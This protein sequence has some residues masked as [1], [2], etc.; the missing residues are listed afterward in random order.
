MLEYYEKKIPDLVTFYKLQVKT[1]DATWFV[2]K[3]FSQFDILL[4][5]LKKQFSTLPELPP[6]PFF[7]L[8]AEALE[9]RKRDLTDLL[10]NLTQRQEILSN[11]IMRS[12]LEI[13]SHCS[14]IKGPSP[15]IV[16]ELDDLP[17]GVRDFQYVHDCSVMFMCLSEMKITSRIDA[18][19][20]NVTFPW[21]KTSENFIIVGAVVCYRVSKDAVSYTHLTLPT[22]RIV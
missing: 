10:K 15:R 12:F 2:E 5:D 14:S 9:K 11:P 6:K 18:Y 8:N 17:L 1:K 3:R 4:K 7:K 19:L 16:A 20:T 21:E 22:K 13:D